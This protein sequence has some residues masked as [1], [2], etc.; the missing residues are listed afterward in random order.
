MG[1]KGSEIILQGLILIAVENTDNGLTLETQKIQ[2]RCEI[3]LS[4]YPY[5]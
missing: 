3:Q 4:Y 2:I 1:Y 5:T